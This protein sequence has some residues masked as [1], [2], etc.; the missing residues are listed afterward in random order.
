MFCA[1]ER[2]AVVSS[3]L[4]VMNE[5]TEKVESD[6]GSGDLSVSSLSAQA[7]VTSLSG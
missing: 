2:S 4:H 1:D 5:G 7:F 3:E 6:E